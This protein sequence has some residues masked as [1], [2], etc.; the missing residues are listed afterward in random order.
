[1]QIIP[2]V[3]SAALIITKSVAKRD[4]FNEKAPHSLDKAA[5]LIYIIDINAP[6]ERVTFYKA[7]AS[8][9]GCEPSAEYYAKIV[10]EQILRNNSSFIR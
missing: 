7:S 2:N 6:T 9:E 5:A 4:C 1:M 10:P 8:L 3:L